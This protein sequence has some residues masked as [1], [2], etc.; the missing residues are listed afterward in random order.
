MWRPP[1]L[2][3]PTAD[4]EAIADAD[5]VESETALVAASETLPSYGAPEADPPMGRDRDLSGHGP[6][7]WA[8]RVEAPLAG[9]GREGEF[10]ATLPR[11]SDR[12]ERLP[13]LLRDATE[14]SPPH[15]PLPAARLCSSRPPPSTRGHCPRREHVRQTG[16]AT[17]GSGS[18]GSSRR[19]AHGA[20]Q[21]RQHKRGQTFLPADVLAGGQ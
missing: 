7:P 13:A 21:N 6:R 17:N 9:A 2:S 11:W 16:I 14:V 5:S 12:V 18:L 3:P 10:P 15:P 20:Q 4:V 19:I 8:G 1:L